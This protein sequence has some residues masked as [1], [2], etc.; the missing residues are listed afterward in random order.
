[1]DGG[2]SGWMNDGRIDGWMDGWKKGERMHAL[3][4]DCMHIERH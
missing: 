1:M 2:T 4:G 3:R